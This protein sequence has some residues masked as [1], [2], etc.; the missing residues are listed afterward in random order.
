MSGD[1]E[2]RFWKKVA[3]TSNPSRCWEWTA[4]K[5]FGGY[6]QFQINQSPF[7]SHRIAYSLAH[8]AIPAERPFIC[9]TCDNPACCNPNHLFAG[10]AEDNMQDM[11]KK[12]RSNFPTG[13]RHGSRTKPGSLPK[14]D[15]HYL[16]KDPTRVLKGSKMKHS[17]LT[18]S[19]VRD[20]RKRYEAGGITQRK[21]AEEFNVHFVTI[22]NVVKRKNWKHVA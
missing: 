7:K 12:G 5:T 22:C 20:I 14:G 3:I 1:D 16:R 10:T 18:E 15:D 9:H 21:L 19:S 6:G 11:L 4:G 13:D 8:G 2:H 17:I